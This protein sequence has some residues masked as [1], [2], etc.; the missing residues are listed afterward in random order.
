MAPP[1]S[2]PD[3][4]EFR[5]RETPSNLID[6]PEELSDLLVKTRS[7]YEWPV[8]IGA[9]RSQEVIKELENFVGLNPLLKRCVIGVGIIEKLKKLSVVQISKNNLQCSR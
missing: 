6:I 5:L 7:E 4:F 8:G 9:D 3:I 1:N 2:Y